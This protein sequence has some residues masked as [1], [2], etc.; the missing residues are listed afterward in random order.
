MKVAIYCRV[1]SEDQ[2]EKKTI[3]NQIDFAKK[4]C[5]L[6]NLEI[7]EWYKDDGVS[8]TIPFEKRSAGRKLLEDAK[9]GKFD[10]VLVYKLDRI[11]RNARIILNTVYEL[12][13]Y[14][15]KIKSMTEPFDTGDTTG[16]FLLTIL[17]GVADLERATILER[18]IQGSYRVAKEGKWLGGPPP[19]GYKVNENGFLEIDKDPLPE[20]GISKAE[21]VRQMFHLIS[22]KKYSTRKVADFLNILKVPT[23]YT[24]D[25][26]PSSGIWRPTVIHGMLKNTVYKGIHIYGKRAKGKKELVYRKVPPIV[27]E[28]TWERTQQILKENKNEAKRNSKRPYLLRGL[29]K[30]GLCG[31]RFTGRAYPGPERRP[32]LYYVCNGK[33]G[34]LH[35]EKERC[36]AQNIPAQW[37]EN[38]VWNEC[39]NFLTNPGETIKELEKILTEKQQKNTLLES[40]YLQLKKNLT[41]KEKEKERILSLYRKGIITEKDVDSQMEKIKEEREE[42]IKTIQKLEEQFQQEKITTNQI[43]NLEK[44]LKF[45]NNKL[46]QN[47]TYEK[48]REI[49]KSLVKEII[50]DTIFDDNN[51]DKRKP[52]KVMVTVKYFF[53]NSVSEVVLLL[54]LG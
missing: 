12:E 46:D 6:H 24:Q 36:K 30:C 44:L 53:S 43:K 41:E 40:E 39:L 7:T 14:N 28:E 22:E 51:H 42:L 20:V 4:Y 49:I 9:K 34:Y 37:I 17:A 15:V 19:Y 38:L 33:E 21:V 23:P 3:E 47:L 5:E 31:R 52:K 29:I 27:D 54:L 8:G 18:C 50:V 11:G 25:K 32:K 26:K 48:K 13:Q 45:L 1:S 2:A 10:T 35:P 16:R